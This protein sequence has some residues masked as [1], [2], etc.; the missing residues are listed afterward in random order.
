LLICLGAPL[1]KKAEQSFEAPAWL[2]HSPLWHRR[3]FLAAYFGAEMTTPA[4]VPGH[5]TVFGAPTV[6]L[7]KRPAHEDSGR[8]F[9]EKV[10]SWLAKFGVQTQAIHRDEAQQNKNGEI[11]IRLRL[12]LTPSSENLCKLWGRVGYE[13][14]RKR[15]NLAALA[16]HYL[17]CKERTLAL[18]T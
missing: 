3:L 1:G 16:V 12:I 18:R 2:E 4:T 11:S 9:L 7:N 10:S 15:S 5:G 14:N 8:K 6:S 17:Q 13:Y